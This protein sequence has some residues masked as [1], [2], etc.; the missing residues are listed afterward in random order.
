MALASMNTASEITPLQALITLLQGDPSIVAALSVGTTFED[1]LTAGIDPKSIGLFSTF[2]NRL[3]DV[4][5]KYII[6]KITVLF[7]EQKHARDNSPSPCFLWPSHGIDYRSSITTRDG[8]NIIAPNLWLFLSLN[9]CNC[10]FYSVDIIETYFVPWLKTI[11]VYF[12]D[13]SNSPL[14]TGL[15]RCNACDVNY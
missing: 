8:V 3:Y 15:P 4:Q 12:L 7:S 6:D 2:W 11:Q 14:H 5:R 1:V 13:A 10:S 9:K